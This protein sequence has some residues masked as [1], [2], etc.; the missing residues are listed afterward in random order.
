[1]PTIYE[2]NQEFYKNVPSYDDD[3]LIQS[4]RQVKG[5]LEKTPF[6][7]YF[8]LMN[9]DTRYCTFFVHKGA[10]FEAL[11]QEI[12]D[13]VRG[14]GNIKSI[15]TNENGYLEFWIEQNGKVYMFALFDYTQG[16]IEVL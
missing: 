6:S 1:M 14:L 7:I 16:V 8:T 3:L 4:I 2:V 13:I 12:I 10:D 15:E 5:F 9:W 11:A